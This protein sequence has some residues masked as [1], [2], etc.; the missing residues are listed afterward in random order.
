MSMGA[1]ISPID[2]DDDHMSTAQS[3]HLAIMDLY[4]GLMRR[5]E[6]EVQAE[7]DARIV[8]RRTTPIKHVDSLDCTSDCPRV[9]KTV[10]SKLSQI[11]RCIGRSL[12][13]FFNDQRSTRN[14]EDIVQWGVRGVSREEEMTVAEAVRLIA[15]VTGDSD[16]EQSKDCLEIIG[17]RA[18]ENQWRKEDRRQWL[19]QEERERTAR[20]A[21]KERI[22]EEKR[23][24]RRKALADLA[25]FAMAV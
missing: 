1:I 3:N 14:E 12:R 17:R 4:I 22:K 15:L 24:V 7:A 5:E 21:E 23:E 10:P 8:A 6:A 13:R 2:N 19:L 16:L 20:L 11:C 25:E 9:H 18:E